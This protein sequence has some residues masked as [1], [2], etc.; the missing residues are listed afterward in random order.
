MDI[1]DWVPW[2]QWRFLTEV[3]SPNVYVSVSKTSRHTQAVPW[4]LE[5]RPPTG[6]HGGN[7]YFSGVQPRHEMGSSQWL[8]K[9]AALRPQLVL[10]LWTMTIMMLMLMRISLILLTR[11][12]KLQEVTGREK[13]EEFSVQKDNK[14]TGFR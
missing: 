5:R 4:S 8:K 12:T 9:A 2:S 7:K 11:S 1:V 10:G 3:Y 13:C 6:F 14:R